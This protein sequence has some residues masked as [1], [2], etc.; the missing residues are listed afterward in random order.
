MKPIGLQ[1]R[2]LDGSATLVFTPPVLKLLPPSD[3]LPVVHWQQVK[4]GNIMYLPSP[5]F[6]KDQRRPLKQA[7]ASD[8]SVVRFHG[9]GLPR[10]MAINKL[11]QNNL[12]GTG[13]IPSYIQR[14]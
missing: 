4:D 13:T 8:V 5:P 6:A 11:A 1:T 2:H 3:T 7:V 10:N 9:A 12:F 14:M